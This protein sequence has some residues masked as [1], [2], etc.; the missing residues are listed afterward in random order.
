MNRLLGPDMIVPPFTNNVTFDSRAIIV[1]Q[2]R[3]LLIA[4]SMHYPRSPPALWPYL[5]S[6]MG[7]AGVNVLDTYVFWDL[8]E[9]SEGVYVFDQGEANLLGFL[10]YAQNAGLMV[11]LRVGPYTCAEYNLGGIPAW[12]VR[13]PGIHF[14]TY[15]EPWMSAM[16]KFSRKVVEVVR[17][18]LATNGGPIILMQLENEYAAFLWK[19]WPYGHHYINWVAR[20]AQKLEPNIPWIMCEQGDIRSVINTCNGFYC[21]DRIAKHRRTFRDQPDMFTELWISWYQL[22]GEPLPTRPVQDVAYSVARFIARGGT[23]ISYYMWHGGTNFAR[24][25]GGPLLATSYDYD[26]PLNEYGFANEPKHSHLAML[27]HVLAQYERVIA[28]TDMPVHATIGDVELHSYGKSSSTQLVFASNTNAQGTQ[29]I[30]YWGLKIPIPP[31]SVSIVVMESTQNATVVFNTA[32]V[33]ASIKPNPVGSLQLL[34]QGKLPD[35]S[36]SILPTNISHV[37]EPI[38]RAVIDSK[39]IYSKEPINQFAVTNDTTD[40]MCL[41]F[42][43][44]GPTDLGYAYLDNQFLGM[45]YNNA[46]NNVSISVRT[47][48]L[49]A[50]TSHTLSILG[51]SDGVSHYAVRLESVTKGVTGRVIING[52]DVTGCGWNMRPGLRGEEMSYATNDTVAIWNALSTIIPPLPLTWYKLGFLVSSLYPMT[53]PTLSTN[54]TAYVLDLSSMTR[55]VVYVNG[56]NVGRYWLETAKN[57]AEDGTSYSDCVPLGQQPQCNYTQT[58]VNNICR[59]GCGS[60]SQRYYHV[61]ASY[62]HEATRLNSS[63]VSVVLLEEVGGDVSQV[64]MIRLQGV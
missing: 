9:P 1:Q 32:T 29:S 46:S 45:I 14:R 27:N 20:L 18:Y 57:V 28:D 62:V 26:A 15:N 53:T 3:R 2:K 4:G 19:Y 36:I 37:S 33:S 22:W 56:H 17:P 34:S 5:L 6:K 10:Q 55:G 52:N 63:S 8:H 16:E 13:K 7:A 38:G 60:A 24:H 21:D 47:D 35:R 12:L 49:N 51:V 64:A 40:Y 30:E 25:S 39:V 44:G 54:L 48:N 11:N 42:T 41:T 58:Y 43:D 59:V 50:T 61:P 23:Y 31:K